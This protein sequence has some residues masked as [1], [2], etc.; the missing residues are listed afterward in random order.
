[1]AFQDPD[2]SAFNQPAPKREEKDWADYLTSGL[3]IAGGIAGGVL[4]SGA[5]PAGAIAGAQLGAGAGGAL[6]G[7]INPYADVGP[8]QVAGGINTALA[9]GKGYAAA[10]TQQEQA[11]L[12]EQAR[13]K[14]AGMRQGVSSLDNAPAPP[15]RLT[16]SPYSYDQRLK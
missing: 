11:R 12:A 14:V 15:P 4:G 3:Q 5:G 1:M 7:L 9:G 13:Q 16:P 6:G 8:A 2:L 10:T